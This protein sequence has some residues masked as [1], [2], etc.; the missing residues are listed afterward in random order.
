MASYILPK[1]GIL[2]WN[3][4]IFWTYRTFLNLLP[5]AGSSQPQ[6]DQALQSFWQAL[7]VAEIQCEPDGSNILTLQSSGFPGEDQVNQQ[8]LLVRKCYED[9]A[10]MMTAHFADGGKVVILRGNP[11]KMLFSAGDK[12]AAGMRFWC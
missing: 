5:D 7:L 4:R 3:D 10:N 2:C 8:K 1:A 11:G 9:L 6:P 12:Q